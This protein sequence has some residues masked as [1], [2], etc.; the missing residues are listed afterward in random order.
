MAFRSPGWKQRRLFRTTQTKVTTVVPLHT[1][2]ALLGK[3]AL[4]QEE[5]M[6]GFRF[7]I[8]W[9]VRSVAV[10]VAQVKMRRYI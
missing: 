10:P 3:E 2:G 6:L 7:M 9:V 4:T 1:D 5:A 8:W